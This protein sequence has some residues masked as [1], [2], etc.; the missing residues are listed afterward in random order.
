MKKYSVI[1]IAFVFSLSLLSGCTKT[2]TSTQNGA[3]GEKTPASNS[4]SSETKTGNPSK[5][6][7]YPLAPSGVLQAEMKTLDGGTVKV[8]D[9]KGTV[10]LLNLWAT[11]CGPCRREMPE[12]VA[13][14]TELKD[15]NFKII[16]LNT[17][18]ESAELINPFVEKMK[19]NYQI[20]WA[21]EK[22]VSEFFKVSKM[23]AIP[24]SFL[25]DREG[26]L[27]GVFVGGSDK[28]IRELRATVEKVVAE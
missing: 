11:W 26:H 27:R 21:D 24:Q 8:G 3:P 4:V 25:I 20:A 9:M 13:L 18:D 7:D 10:V 15:K 12:L 17:D 16:G 2:A 6:S 14:E 1:F 5:S 23:S 19:L 22:L 28:V